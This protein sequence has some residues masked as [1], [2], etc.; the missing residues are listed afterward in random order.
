[1]SEVQESLAGR[2]C[3]ENLYGLS[4]REINGDN[5]DLF[6]PSIELLK[7]RKPTKRLEINT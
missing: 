6:I 2:V 3:I 5:I 4:T 7:K 1:M